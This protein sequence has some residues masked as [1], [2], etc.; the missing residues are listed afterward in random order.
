M[1]NRKILALDVGLKR[2]G[3]ALSLQKNIVT[4][5]EAIQ[6]K[7]RDQASQAVKKLIKEWG[8]E[9]LVVG[10]PIENGEM[11]RRIKHFVSLIE[12]D[13]DIVYQDEGYSSYEA[14]ELMVGVT[15]N[16]KDGKSDSIAAKLILERYLDSN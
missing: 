2:I 9:L 16:R 6:R 14:E 5:L 12:Y 15:K 13:K 4:P 7:N 3:V 11:V 8:I 10:L 1:E